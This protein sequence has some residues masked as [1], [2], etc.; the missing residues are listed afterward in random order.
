MG[1]LS[2]MFN[3]TKNIPDETL[4]KPSVEVQ[5][6]DEHQMWLRLSTHQEYSDYL[7]KLFLTV[8]HAKP[9]IN[10]ELHDK[11][12]AVFRILIQG[13]RIVEPWLL[14]NKNH[15]EI[16]RAVVKELTEAAAVYAASMTE[17]SRQ[18][19]AML[20]FTDVLVETRKV[21]K[22]AIQETEKVLPSYIHED[23]ELYYLIRQIHTFSV[24]MCRSD[25]PVEHKYVAESTLHTVLP[26]TLVMYVRS[27][28]QTAKQ[29]RTILL[30]QLHEIL[31][32]MEDML[33]EVDVSY[34][35]SLNAHTE[36]LKQRR[37]QY[38]KVS[39][40]SSLSLY[41]SPQPEQK[42]EMVPNTAVQ[43]PDSDGKSHETELFTKHE[44]A[45]EG[46]K[47]EKCVEEEMKRKRLRD[48]S[49]TTWVY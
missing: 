43:E 46:I 4:L 18:L 8:K 14:P 15:A 3:L 47:P 5:L 28:P 31:G 45:V 19:Q 27:S 33:V 26:D 22:E 17:Y 36:Y 44:N 10:H 40:T 32:T 2:R 34:I 23:K 25:V 12:V 20:N 7:Q 38:G 6:L 39:S 11:I 21:A 16:A 49:V 42:A 30:D 37:A 9:G 1:W 24:T 29:A 41:F 13:L 35:N 48:G